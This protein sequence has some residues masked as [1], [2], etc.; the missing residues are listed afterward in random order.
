MDTCGTL[1]EEIQKLLDA[2]NAS[3]GFP[4]T[5]GNAVE[6]LLEG[7]EV[8]SEL[9]G[10]HRW[11]DEEIRVV[12]ID[13]NLFQYAWY[14]VTGDTSISDMGLDFDLSSVELV[15]EYT[16]TVVVTKYRPIP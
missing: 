7:R 15:E 6:A 3:K 5:I 9:G 2:H 12:E 8:F 14:H 16:E 1:N 4:V 13:G 11:Y 10:S